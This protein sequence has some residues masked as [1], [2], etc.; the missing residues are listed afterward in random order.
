MRL[1]SDPPHEAKAR[2]FLAEDPKVLDALSSLLDGEQVTSRSESWVEL[3]QEPGLNHCY[4]AEIQIASLSTARQ[5]FTQGIKSL[6]Y[7]V[8]SSEGTIHASKDEA[9]AALIT[10]KADEALFSA[11]W[12]RERSPTDAAVELFAGMPGADRL[13]ELLTKTPAS[14]DS[15]KLMW[16]SEDELTLMTTGDTDDAAKVAAWLSEHGYGTIQ[17]DGNMS[18]GRTEDGF[19][20]VT[21]VGPSEDETPSSWMVALTRASAPSPWSD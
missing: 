19:D 7:T 15:S 12:K 4:G 1:H 9:S 16:T 18:Q 5:Q 17:A 2:T 10:A 11:S 14:P 21:M 8:E 13:S 6:G 3:A 20:T